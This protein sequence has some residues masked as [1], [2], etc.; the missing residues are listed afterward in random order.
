MYC[1]NNI[2]SSMKKSNAKKSDEN[3][4]ENDGFLLGKE[5][6]DEISLNLNSSEI[7]FICIEKRSG[8]QNSIFQGISIFINEN[9]TALIVG[10]F[11]TPLAYDS[12]KYA[13]KA[14][15]EKII[16][17]KVIN[18]GIVGVRRS[19]ELVL[20]LKTKNGNIFA[21]IPTNLSD[22][23]FGQYMDTLQESLKVLQ[24]DSS[25][26][27]EYVAEYDAE[28]VKVCLRTMSEYGLEQYRK[29]LPSVKN[30][31]SPKE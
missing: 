15:A 12:I 27:Q 17:K 18:F 1:I 21:P 20:K 29:Q 11:I 8:I 26:Y 9:L 16:A 7:G 19:P 28:L 23:Q 3:I 6:E 13:V 14:I 25:K 2:E 5:T 24:N 4:L 10:G 22:K 30:D 31:N